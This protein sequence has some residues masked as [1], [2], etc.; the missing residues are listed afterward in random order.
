MSDIKYE[1]STQL[2]I[3]NFKLFYHVTIVSYHEELALGGWPQPCHLH[4]VSEPHWW[5]K[6]KASFLVIQLG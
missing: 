4:W 3:K 2:L 5:D 1:Q 6:D